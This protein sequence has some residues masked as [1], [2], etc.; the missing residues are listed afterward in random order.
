M[1]QTPQHL[2]QQ[3]LAQLEAT[4]QEIALAGH[5]LRA[6]DIRYLCKRQ[7][8]SCHQ[9]SLV[10]INHQIVYTIA[11]TLASSPYIRQ[12]DFVERIADFMHA[13]YATRQYIKAT[14]YDEQL[15][16]LLYQHYLANFGEIHSEMVYACIQQVRAK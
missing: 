1:I 10:D 7:K 8:Q 4:N 12:D 5:Q 9:F 13:Y 2:N 6:K 16:A 11:T 15:V 14:L 3:Q